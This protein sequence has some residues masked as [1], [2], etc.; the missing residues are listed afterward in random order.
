MTVYGKVARPYP[1]QTKENCRSYPNSPIT[2][3]GKVQ[4]KAAHPPAKRR[5]PQP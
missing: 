2:I 5:E 4:K 1:I 3:F